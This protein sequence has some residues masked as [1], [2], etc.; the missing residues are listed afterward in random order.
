M[1]D[2]TNRYYEFGSFSVDVGTRVLLSSGKPVPL[3]PKVLETLLVMIENRGR[4]L[5][6]DEL[7]NLVWGDT[8]VE[9]G[10]LTRNVSVLRKVLGE[11]PDDHQYIVTV[12]DR[13]LCRARR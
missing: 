3:T 8:I 7:L 12:P 5:T 2:Q 9:E 13:G 4:V 6:K 10:G 1:S 11:R